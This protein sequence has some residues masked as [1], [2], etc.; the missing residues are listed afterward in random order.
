MNRRI[1]GASAYERIGLCGIVQLTI[2]FHCFLSLF[3]CFLFLRR[4]LR[5]SLWPFQSD[6]NVVHLSKLPAGDAGG[7][8][9]QGRSKRAHGR[10]CYFRA[11]W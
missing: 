4:C 5:S 11:K 10:G 6:L 7:K 8:G 3:P 1:E 9:S 2:S